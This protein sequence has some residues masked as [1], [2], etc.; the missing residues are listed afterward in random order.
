MSENVN[1]GFVPAASAEPVQLPLARYLPPIPDGMLRNWLLENLP[2]GSPILD[3]FCASPQV[4]LECAQAGYPVI[5]TC[6]NPLIRNI[7]Q[8]LAEAPSASDLVALVT[9]VGDLQRGGSRLEESLSELYQTT[10]PNCQRVIQTQYYLWEKGEKYPSSRFIHCPVCRTEGEFEIE[11]FDK[12]IL[13]EKIH[14]EMHRVRAEL[15]NAFDGEVIEGVR[16]AVATY[17][18]RSLDFLFTL[19]N[20]LPGMRLSPTKKGWLQTMLI[21]L[22]DLG[23]SM[24]D[25]SNSRTRPKQIGDP[26]RFKEFN[27]WLE[28]L[29]IARDWQSPY[30]RQTYREIGTE[31]PETLEGI[32]LFAG[33]FREL[34]NPQVME[35]IQAFVSIIPRPNQPF[36][37]YSALWTGW[38]FGT[39]ALEGIKGS[40]DRKRYGWQ[41]QSGALFQLFK[42]CA[43]KTKDSKRFFSLAGEMNTG[44]L[45]SILTASENAGFKLTRFGQDE[46]REIAQFVWE[47]DQNP[48][49]VTE[50]ALDGQ[51]GNLQAELVRFLE[52]TVQP[53][54]F[55]S[56]YGQLLVHLCSQGKLVQ[57]LERIPPNYTGKLQNTISLVFNNNPRLVR[58]DTTSE[59]LESGYWG[60]ETLPQNAASLTD[61]LE[62]FIYKQLEAHQNIP[63]AELVSA[64]YRQFP[65]LQTP[66]MSTIYEILQ[67]YANCQEPDPLWSQKL[68][69]YAASRAKDIQ[70]IQTVLARLAKAFGLKSQSFDSRTDWLDQQGTIKL[71][72]IVQSHANLYLSLTNPLFDPNQTYIIHP[73]SR[74]NLIKYKINQDPQLESLL[75]QGW[76][77]GKFRRVR[78]SLNKLELNYESWLDFIAADAPEW[79]KPQQLSFF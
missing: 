28:L 75:N 43:E 50:D 9:E 30:E 56:L 11:A 45:T 27:L 40:L 64:V 66:P 8:T 37:T 78:E 1:L 14:D 22:C 15:R 38:I 2:L 46:E 10:C 44:F 51:Q 63:E 29:A 36:W 21:M 65:G 39:D 77:F 49:V 20:R 19:I 58:Y 18:P 76:R 6:N 60:L 12:S 7:T 54:T 32:H 67:S 16:E 52:K 53:G 79:E 68:E 48:S 62:Q 71:R 35:A 41:W 57:G 61:K 4:A 26:P 42:S 55:R 47:P 25:V 70:A 3:P 73:G 59:N 72:L 24:W 23:N 74:S 69:E 31:M 33:R 5:V 17:L 34:E 13:D